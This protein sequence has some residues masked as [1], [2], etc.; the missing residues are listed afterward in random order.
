MGGG[1]DSRNSAAELD[2]LGDPVTG[3]RPCEFG[4]PLRGVI[5]EPAFVAD[6][7]RIA[8]PTHAVTVAE[9]PGS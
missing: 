4:P 7:Q 1:C 8:T 3:R 2:C 9:G 5:R 6:L